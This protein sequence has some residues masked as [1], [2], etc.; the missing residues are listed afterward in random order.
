M[1]ELRWAVP[2]TGLQHKRLQMRQMVAVINENT[3][4]FAGHDWSDWKDVPMEFVSERHSSTLSE[5]TP[6]MFLTGDPVNF[7]S[8]DRV[9]CLACGKDHLS[10]NLNC[11]FSHADE[12]KHV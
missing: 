4:G 10:L 12:A 9:A 7:A 8:S 2:D 11:D 3:G 1:I 5:I 6:G